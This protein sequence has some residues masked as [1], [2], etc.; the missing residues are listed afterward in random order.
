MGD[1]V[2]QTVRV[3]QGSIESG[4][5]T[6]NLE[7]GGRKFVIKGTHKVKSGGQIQSQRKSASQ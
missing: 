7:R 3:R 5:G 6:R 1:I 4:T 2:G